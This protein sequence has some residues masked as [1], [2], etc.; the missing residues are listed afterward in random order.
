ML[1]F[2]I[3]SS[4]LAGLLEAKQRFDL[5]NALRVPL[6]LLAYVAPLLVLPFSR[7]LVPVVAVLGVGRALGWLGHLVL[8]MRVY[9]E[10]RGSIEVRRTVVP[11]L[12]SSR[13]V[14]DGKQFGKSL[15]D[16]PRPLPRRWA[17]LDDRGRALCDALRGYNPADPPLG[18]GR[19]GALPALRRGLCDGSDGHGS[20]LHPRCRG[21][22]H[23]DVRVRTRTDALILREGLQL[24]LARSSH[25]RAPACS[26]S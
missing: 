19:G 21:R 23:D 26:S 16:V 25:R 13:G 22:R 6:G 24:W 7:S 12:L 11:R 3:G 20:A 8:C 18:R 2:V 15:D 14:D 5:L 17:A 4:A 10:L 9:P 1:P